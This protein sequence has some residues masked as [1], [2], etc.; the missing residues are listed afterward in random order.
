MSPAVCTETWR[1]RGGEDEPHRV[2]PEADAQERVRFRGDAADLDEQLL[3]RVVRVVHGVHRAATGCPMSC[4]VRRHGRRRAPGSRPPKWRHS[5]LRPGGGHRRVPDARLGH[6]HHIGRDARRQRAGPVLVD[7][8]GAEVTLVDP[9]QPGPG[10][11]G[12]VSSSLV[13][14]LDQGG[15]ARG[16]RPER[17]SGPTPRRRGRPRSGAPHRRP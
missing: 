6:G 1:G 7:L 17:E 3:V 12:P 14:D 15:Q 11:Q 4:G 2:G 10:G 8:E 16:R 13:V 9:D 5:R